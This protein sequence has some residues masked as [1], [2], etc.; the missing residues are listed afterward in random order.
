MLDALAELPRETALKA[1]SAATAQISPIGDEIESQRRD[2]VDLNLVSKVIAEV[3]TRTKT[4]SG[5]PA[6]VKYRLRLLADE[7]ARLA[8]PEGGENYKAARDRMGQR[9]DL[10]P[11]LY[12]IEFLPEFIRDE[13]HFDV[14]RAQISRVVSECDAVQHLNPGKLFTQG[15]EPL[16]LFARTVPDTRGNDYT[17]LVVAV[18]SGARLGISKAWRL[19][20]SDLRLTS[21]IEP[22]DLLAAFLDRFGMP[23]HI[24][25]QEKK[26]FVYEIIEIDQMIDRTGGFDYLGW[27]AKAGAQYIISNLQRVTEHRVEVAMAYVVNVT[28]YKAALSRHRN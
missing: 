26:L 8:V 10:S 2:E 14:T 23:L 24:G 5:D 19:Y 1:L 25:T 11:Q 20:H 6:T 22:L 4:S 3:A 9:G 7:I 27:H 12:T 28:Q 16:S 18:R 17:V 21:A 15:S 13:R